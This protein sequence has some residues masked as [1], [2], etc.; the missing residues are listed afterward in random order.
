MKWFENCVKI[1]KG[2]YILTKSD[3]KLSGEI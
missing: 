3:L 2:S 1:N